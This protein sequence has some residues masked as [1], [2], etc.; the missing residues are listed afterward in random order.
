MT[1]QLPLFPTTRYQGSKR[2]MTEWIWENVSEFTFDSVLDVFGG[3]A[4]VSHLFKRKGK[5][6]TYNDYLAF[7]HTIGLA[8]DTFLTQ[9]D[10]GNFLH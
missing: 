1:Q 9:D 4:V 5:S 10:S 3:T 2:Q 6:V 8:L 7:N